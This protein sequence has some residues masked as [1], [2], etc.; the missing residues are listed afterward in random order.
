[1]RSNVCSLVAMSAKLIKCVNLRS[2][3]EC[4]GWR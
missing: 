1:M 3:I 2:D 4:W